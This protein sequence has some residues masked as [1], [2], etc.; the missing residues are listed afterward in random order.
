L[1]E[2]SGEKLLREYLKTCTRWKDRNVQKVGRTLK[3]DR[4]LK[5]GVYVY[6]QGS[7]EIHHVP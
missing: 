1:A 5:A 7:P 6:F 3:G 4:V 2:T